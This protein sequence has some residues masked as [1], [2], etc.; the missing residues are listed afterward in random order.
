V[1]ESPSKFA[2]T[3]VNASDVQYRNDPVLYHPKESFEMTIK[4]KERKN[5]QRTFTNHIDTNDVPRAS[6]HDG[7][8][9]Y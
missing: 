5:L 4:E 2:K 1:F 7:E 9:M 3:S 8:N 6:Y